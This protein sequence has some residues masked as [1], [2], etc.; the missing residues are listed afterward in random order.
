MTIFANH[1]NSFGI[2]RF[3]MPFDYSALSIHKAH[4]ITKL[5]NLSSLSI[6]LFQ[7]ITNL[8]IKFYQFFIGK[9]FYIHRF[10]LFFAARI[11]PLFC[12]LYATNM[13][14]KD[15]TQKIFDTA[16]PQLL[17]DWIR[18]LANKLQETESELADANKEIERLNNKIKKLQGLPTKPKFKKKDKTS[19]LESKADDQGDDPCSRNKRKEAAKKNR[20]KKKELK[21]DQKKKISIDASMLDESFINK[22]SRKVVI[23]EINFSSNNMEF[24]LER[25]WSPI[26]GLVEAELPEKYK[27]SFY[28]PKLKAFI[29]S[30]YYHGNVTIKK[31]KKILQAIGIEISIRQINR[32]INKVDERLDRELDEARKQGIAKANYQQID[33]TGA[34]LC[35]SNAYTT[36]T[37]NPYFS[38]LFTSFRKNRTNAVLAL[39][40]GKKAPVYKLNDHA[41]M[42]AYLTNKS[43]RLQ[44]SLERFKSTKVYSDDDIDDFFEREEMRGFRPATKEMIKTSML[45]GA[46]YDGELGDVGKALV[47]DD[48]GQ[49]S[50]LYDDHLLCWA[51]EL[52]HYKDLEP[53]FFEHREELE[54]FKSE[55]RNFY[56]ALKKWI[57]VRSEDGREHLFKWFNEL[58]GSRSKYKLLDERKRKSF[59][60]MDRLLA[61][62]F[63]EVRLP[64]DNNESERDIRARVIKR[65]ISLFNRTRKGAK[66]WDFYIGLMKTCQKNRIS[67][68]SFLQDRLTFTG[69]IPQ[70]AEIIRARSPQL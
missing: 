68:Y 43:L 53:H 31:I 64:L 2:D 52:R 60:K 5:K 70:L 6:Q 17:K 24:E 19:D 25:Y 8:L 38:S 63:S 44:L 67:F 57:R 9:F 26:F 34:N 40:G 23:Q 39:A 30:S 62:L 48:A 61:A 66:A 51:H 55:A 14:I 46:F 58:F 3:D 65:K 37:C 21:I 10:T 59:D 35:F 4:I 12:P 29:L 15:I 18:S 49:F 33:D 41:I 22:G 50:Q 45:V 32:I 1:S 16:T 56:R 13:S 69:Q 54:V 20:A 42:T 27:G 7:S 28:G 36:V 47:S 11:G